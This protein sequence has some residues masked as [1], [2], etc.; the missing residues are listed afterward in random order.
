[1]FAIEKMHRPSN[2][3]LPAVRSQTSIFQTLFKIIY[4]CAITIAT[5]GWLWLLTRWAME[6]MI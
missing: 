1:M 6:L 4:L 2:G 3:K 5:L